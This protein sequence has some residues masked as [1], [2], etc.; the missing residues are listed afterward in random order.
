M[1]G[2]REESME[3]ALARVLAC[4]LALSGLAACVSLDGPNATADGGFEVP[5]SDG[6][7]IEW[8]G[9]SVANPCIR[10]EWH[11]APYVMGFDGSPSVVA[12][13]VKG[14][15]LRLEL[16]AKSLFRLG[17]HALDM[18]FTDP[19]HRTVL[20]VTWNELAQRPIDS[21]LVLDEVP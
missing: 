15:A 18:R 10:G 3:L 20:S 13:T 2:A 12:G 21:Q 11:D 14:R 9:C 19:P 5:E 6:I 1:G 8:R 17:A 16:D 7:L 4:G